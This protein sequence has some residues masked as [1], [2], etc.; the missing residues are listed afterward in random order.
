MNTLSII[1]P[2]FNEE[3][4]LYKTFKA[5]LTL[6]LPHG[7]KLEEVIFVN[8]G[9][10]DTSLYLLKRFRANSKLPVKIL[11]YGPNKGKGYAVR[12]GM[13]AS[14]SNYALL[15]DADI[16]TPF[17]EINK[18]MTH[19][20]AGKEVIVGTRKNGHST[21]IIHQPKFREVL[22]KLFTLLTKLFLGISV[23]DF[24]CGFKL[25]SAHS[26][27][28]IF[29]KTKIDR[30][31]YDAEVLYLAIRQ[32]CGVVECPVLWSDDKG[33]HVN[34]VRAVPETLWELCK[35]HYFHTITPFYFKVTK[36]FTSIRGQFAKASV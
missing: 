8:D 22:G 19:I 11:S 30:W 20:Q 27:E 23:T 7:L 6:E 10:R 2:V 21:V 18:F 1:I 28:K 12:I 15:A 35:I 33:T 34:L 4:R 25:F 13:L 3:K 31:G 26:I 14:V 16:S 17:E 5:L 9:S 24:T 36:T 29:P 32:H